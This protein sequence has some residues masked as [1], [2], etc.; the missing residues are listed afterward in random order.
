LSAKIGTKTT[1]IRGKDYQTVPGR[2]HTF[3]V[4]LGY[5]ID[6]GWAIVTEPVSVTDEQV[7]FRAAILNPSG[8]TVATGH[9]EEKWA[10]S[11]VNSTSAVENC[12]TSAVG[13]ALAMV[14]LGGEQLCSAEELLNALAAQEMHEDAS[15]SHVSDVEDEHEVE[16]AQTPGSPQKEDYPDL[17]ALV[18]VSK[19]LIGKAISLMGQ[20][21]YDQWH[22]RVILNMT[23]VDKLGEVN[24]PVGLMNFIDAQKALI[25]R[26][27]GE[28]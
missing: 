12:E 5:T 14:G 7:V 16:V 11:N 23:G 24:N 28:E 6:K 20:E 22:S 15:E 2:I 9:A 26:E 13:R 1:N 4:D 19:G 8:R 21:N 17:D 27:E 3:R 18:S 10:S 25:K